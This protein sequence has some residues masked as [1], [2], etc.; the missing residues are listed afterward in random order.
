MIGDPTL[1]QRDDMVEAGWRIVIAAARF[2]EGAASARVSELSGGI[3][4]TERGG[5]SARDATA[6]SGAFTTRSSAPDH[7]TSRIKAVKRG[8]DRT[9]SAAGLMREVQK[10]VAAFLTRL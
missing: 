7:F 1:F 6:A 9:G 10:V 8:S 3:V 4:G 5:P 2:V